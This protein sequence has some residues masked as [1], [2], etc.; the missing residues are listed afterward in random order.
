MTFLA[1]GVCGN[2]PTVTILDQLFDLQADLAQIDL[3]VLQDVCGNAATFLDEAQ[4]DVFGANVF[5]VK[6]LSLLVG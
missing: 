2:L 1:R 6:S 4:Q 3:E 5:V